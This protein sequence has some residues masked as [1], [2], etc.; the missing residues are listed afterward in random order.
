MPILKVILPFF[1]FVSSALADDFE[2]FDIFF[3]QS[4]IDTV[5]KLKSFLA[6]GV[7]PNAT[8]KKGYTL[9]HK[10]IVNHHTEAARLLV[11]DYG[12]DVNVRFP[13]K[14]L[15]A[16]ADYFVIKMTTEEPP[17][18]IE[19]TETLALNPP[20][21]RTTKRPYVPLA[22]V[23][24]LLQN[25][26]DTSVTD[27]PINKL[28]TA[29]NNTLIRV[30]Y[31]LH[32][33]PRDYRRQ[34]IDLLIRYKINLNAQ[35]KQKETALH[36][37][38]HMEDLDTARILIRNN[39]R[40]DLTNNE[41]MTPLQLAKHISNPDISSRSKWYWYFSFFD[42]RYKFI[43]LLQEAEARAEIQNESA[44]KISSKRSCKTSFSKS[45]QGQS[46][47]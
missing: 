29:G 39:A 41:G 40:L 12:A 31:L 11:L 7:D 28:S 34:F 27:Q 1:V 20:P 36:A 15:Y 17:P 6:S 13:K 14:D 18:L 23:E 3:Q 2:N 30:I 25:G 45:N 26:L 35:N 32:I 5:T 9:L 8:D 22:L 44:K 46:K 43:K 24:L 21:L 42:K 16:E 47:L 10:A 19:I 38:I 4:G 33:W 37:T